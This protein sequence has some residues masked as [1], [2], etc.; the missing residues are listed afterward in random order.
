VSGGVKI[1]FLRRFAWSSALMMEICERFP[2]K[3]G[4][5]RAEGKRICD[6]DLIIGVRARE[7]GLTAEYAGTVASHRGIAWLFH[8]VPSVSHLAILN[9]CSLTLVILEECLVLAASLGPVTL[10][11]RHPGSDSERD[12]FRE[13]AD[14]CASRS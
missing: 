13:R 9:S 3:R 12:R 11:K 1:Y 14:R 4:R 10:R 6:F 8:A 7:H 2:R 5:L